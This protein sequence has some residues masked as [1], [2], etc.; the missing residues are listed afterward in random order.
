MNRS[1][2]V[3]LC[4][5]M[6]LFAA[7]GLWSAGGAE[8]PMAP[9]V[10]YPTE[11]IRV[12]VP[13]SAGGASDVV[14]RL[15]QKSVE[16]SLPQ[17][18]IIVN[19]PGAGTALGSRE[20]AT[21]QPNGYS[22]LMM[23]EAMLSASAQRRFD[24]GWETLEPVALTGREPYIVVVQDSSDVDTL[25]DLFSKARSGQVKCAVNIGG[26]NHL[27]SLIVADAGAVEFQ[28]VQYA[29]GADAVKA[30]LGGHVDVI[31]SVM[32]ES[33][34][35]LSSGDFRAIAVLSDSRIE[36]ISDVPTSIEQG[37]DA[38]SELN[39]MWWVPRGTPQPRQDILA[40]ALGA[41]MEDPDVLQVFATRN[42]QPIFLSGAELEQRVERTAS[43]VEDLV[44]R[45]DLYAN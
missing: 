20:V 30:L 40:E 29:G 26:L 43:V 36:A 5:V 25:D 21:S 27:T 12:V 8:E 33:G 24:L 31:F 41:A 16:S 6:M 35:Y 14:A 7:V 45:F 34:P 28:P 44:E 13:S 42:I 32:G 11:P 4:A 22:V 9:D 38:S 23:H 18:F 2:R 3:I 15:F 1:R 39:H 17:P 19:I 10:E 37:Y